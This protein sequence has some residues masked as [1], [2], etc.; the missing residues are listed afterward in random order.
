V[1][2]WSL[3]PHHLDARG[4]VALW[5]EGLLARAV[6]VGTT[7]GY[8]HHPQLERFREHRS[9]VAAIDCYLSH[10]FDEARAR[11]YA[12]DESKICYPKRRRSSLVVTSGQLEHEWAHLLGKLKVRDPSCWK[13]ERQGTPEPHPCFRVVDG[14]VARWE[15]SPSRHRP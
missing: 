15:R 8:R 7:V 4:L 5:R 3:H 10:V 11:S 6:L 1:R 9:P 12:F 2:L 13:R 14:P